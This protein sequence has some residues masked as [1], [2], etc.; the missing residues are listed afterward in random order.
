MSS[1]LWDGPIILDFLRSTLSGEQHPGYRKAYRWCTEHD[2]HRFDQYTYNTPKC[3]MNLLQRKWWAWTTG[4]CPSKEHLELEQRPGLQSFQSRAQ[5]LYVPCTASHSN[6]SL[7]ENLNYPVLDTHPTS[8]GLL[9]SDDI[10]TTDSERT[11]GYNWCQHHN[12]DIKCVDIHTCSR[13]QS[14]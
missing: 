12:V 2:L 7:P 9:A 13:S 10:P 5:R 4:R 8:S 14:K 1:E 11:R 6:L 3:R